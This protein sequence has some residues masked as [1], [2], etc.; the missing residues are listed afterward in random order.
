[1]LEVFARRIGFCIGW[2]QEM[3]EDAIGVLE[4]Y[5]AGRRACREWRE[6][7]YVKLDPSKPKSKWVKPDWFLEPR[8]RRYYKEVPEHVEKLLGDRAAPLLGRSCKLPL[9]NAVI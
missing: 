4:N 6:L 5:G 2:K 1:M 3:L 7:G 9:S 8:Y